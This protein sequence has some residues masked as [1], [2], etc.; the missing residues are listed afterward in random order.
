[1]NYR[2]MRTTTPEA[3]DKLV[4]DLRSGRL[5]SDVP[6]HGTLIRVRRSGGLRAGRAEVAE[7]RTQAKAARD[8]RAAAQEEK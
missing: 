8:G 6:A 1:V 5:D 4:E 3:F 2:Y 7:Q